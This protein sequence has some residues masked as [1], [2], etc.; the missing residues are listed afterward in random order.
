MRSAVPSEPMS[1]SW[2]GRRGGSSTRSQTSAISSSSD[3]TKIEETPLVCEVADE[4]VDLGLGVQVDAAGG[5]VEQQDAH[6]RRPAPGRSRPSA[7]FRR[8]A[9]RSPAAARTHAP[10]SRSCASAT[11]CASA[12]ALQPELRQHPAAGGEQQVLT[13]AEQRHDARALAVLGGVGDAEVEHLAGIAPA[14][15]CAVDE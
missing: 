8:R 7:G 10:T 5:F 15:R 4:P 11:I 2:M 12:L 9:C 1:S 3:E 6:L 14:L 13:D